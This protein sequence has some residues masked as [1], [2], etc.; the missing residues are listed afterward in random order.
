M[1]KIIVLKF[2]VSMLSLFFVFFFVRCTNTNLSNSTQFTSSDQQDEKLIL[3]KWKVERIYNVVHGKDVDESDFNPNTDSIGL[4]LLFGPSAWYSSVG[5]YF[6]FKENGELETNI[7]PSEYA[8]LLNLKYKNDKK[9][10]IH[11]IP[12]LEGEPIVSYTEIIK[13]SETKMVWELDNLLMV[14]L[15]KI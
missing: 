11:A 3:G 9:L 1:S 6:H 7:F 2:K 10:I 14:T 15:V 4:V 13:L 8:E 5:K 12:K